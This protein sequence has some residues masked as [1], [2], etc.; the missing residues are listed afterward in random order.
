MCELNLKKAKHDIEEVLKDPALKI[1]YQIE[2]YADLM[3]IIQINE[4]ITPIVRYAYE[5]YYGMNQA[6]IDIIW[7][8]NYFDI[9]NDIFRKPKDTI[10]SLT[11]KDLLIEI[12]P[13]GKSVQPSFVSKLLHTLN[14][15]EPIYD[16][17]VRTFLGIGNPKG[18]TTE[19]R[20]ES[21]V[22]IYEKEIKDGFYEN[23]KYIE[24]R[25][26]MLKIFDKKYSVGVDV[27]D[28]KKLDFVI[29]AMGKRNRCILEF[30]T[31]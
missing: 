6:G 9:A 13:C 2:L 12:G 19:A 28:V 24:L 8:N 22:Y 26:M 5:R 16:S 29:W 25:K 1:K 14:D 18:N 7:K 17:C 20:M 10:R 27:S 4:K 3:R 11:L 21:A 30:D 23:D 31:Y 15:N